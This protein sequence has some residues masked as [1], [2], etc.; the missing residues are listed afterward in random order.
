[1]RIADYRNLINEM[2]Y[3]NQS[4]DIKR[5]NWIFNN[6][7]DRIEGL[8]NGKEGTTINRFD[9]FNSSGDIENFIIKTLMW[10]FPTKGRGN[11]ISKLLEE[12]TFEK[13]VSMLEEYKQA[14]ISINKLEEDINSIKGLGLST[15]SKF[16]YFLKAKIDGFQSLIMD[17]QIINTINLERFD[18]LKGM[19]GIRYDN[20]INKYVDYLWTI[21]NLSHDLKVEPDKIEMF[22]FSF[23]R[24]LSELKGEEGDYSEL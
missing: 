5:S 21:T 18:E 16:I 14:D 9:L 10:G 20:A 4:F 22:L 8:F 24:N 15:M 19:R 23:G 13:L 1:M 3:E 6:Q 17:L 2:P 12:K 11:N 7:K